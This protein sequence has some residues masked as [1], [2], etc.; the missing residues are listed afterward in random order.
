MRL[1]V[2]CKFCQEANGEMKLLHDMP[3][4]RVVRETSQQGACGVGLGKVRKRLDMM[5]G[6]LG[7]RGG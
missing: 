6:I 3:N 4:G 1:L 5:E 7:G 2:R